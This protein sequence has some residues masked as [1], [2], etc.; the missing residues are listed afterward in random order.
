MVTPGWVRPALRLSVAA[1]L[2]MKLG[3]AQVQQLHLAVAAEHQVGRLDVAMHQLMFVGVLKPQCRLADDLARRA[4]AKRT[5][6]RHVHADELLQVDAV[7]ELHHQEMDAAGLAR[8][9]G[10]HDV[11]MIQSSDRLHLAAEAA[12]RL[13]IIQVAMGKDFQGDRLVE[14]DLP[15]LVDDAHAAVAQF[16]QQFVVAQAARFDDPA[17]NALD[18][19]G[20]FGK[21]AAILFQLQK[22]PAALAEVE[23]DL[24]QFRPAGGR[25]RRAGAWS[26]TSSISGGLPAWHALSN[27]SHIW[28]MR[29]VDETCDCVGSR[30]PCW[31]TAGAF[32]RVGEP[33]VSYH[34]G[35]EESSSKVGWAE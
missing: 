24:Q 27:W 9:V 16:L 23:F 7:D 31:L 15:G 11:R 32:W 22:G 34:N 5:A 8:V 20:A 12:D 2:G 6:G 4:D 1:P 35:Q 30:L 13:G 33:L 28:S 14:I 25:A 17:E 21:S 19:L 29:P 18:Q 26:K 10:P 3:Q